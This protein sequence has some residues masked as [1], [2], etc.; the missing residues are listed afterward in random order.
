MDFA[1]PSHFRTLICIQEKSTSYHSRP[2]RAEVGCAWWLLC[3]PSPKVISATHQLLR[4]SS[5]VSNRRVPHR[6]V[7]EFTSQVAC[8]PTTTRKHTPHSTSGR[9]PKAYR[10]A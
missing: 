5:V 1:M 6:C 10:I 7:A 9:P 3:Q 4:E 2:C 8:R